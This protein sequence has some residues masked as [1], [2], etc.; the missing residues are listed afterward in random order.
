MKASWR[1]LQGRSF[2][3]KIS[4]SNPQVVSIAVKEF[5]KGSI[6]VFPTDTSYGLGT[7]GLKWNNR[8]VKRIFEI[9]SRS[10][11]KPI[12]LLITKSMISRFIETSSNVK[13]ILEKIW[14]SSVTII[15]LCNSQALHE[16]SPYLNL[17]NPQKIAFRVPQHKLLLK[18]IEKVNSPIIGTSANK[19]GS[20]SKYDLPSIIRELS[21]GNIHLWIDAGELPKNP[22][23]TIVDLTD[24]INPTLVRKGNVDIEKILRSQV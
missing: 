21:F 22:P 3:V 20:Q 10:P 1:F 11:D 23:S 13:K 4:I 12:S 17:K 14:P 7:I 9:K 18:I 24:P 5:Q 16:L 8:N 15:L 19:S 6:V 2:L